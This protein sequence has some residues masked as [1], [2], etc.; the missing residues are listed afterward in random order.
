MDRKRFRRRP[1]MTLSLAVPGGSVVLPEDELEGIAADAELLRR[2]E[3]VSELAPPAPGLPSRRL[4]LLLL[5]A[6]V[7]AVVY[8][9]W[10]IVAGPIGTPVVFALLAAAEMFSIL[11]LLGFWWTVWHAD[12]R[13]PPTR[14][15]DLSVDALVTTCGEPVEVV[16]ATVRAVV[17]MRGPHRTILLDD[18]GRPEMRELAERAGAEY[19]ARGS[20][21]GAKAGNLNFGLAHATGD[22]VAAFDADHRPRPE[23]LER[24]LPYMADP[25][26]AWV[27]TP[28]YY[29]DSTHA[30]L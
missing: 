3:E 24:T 27:Q 23:F 2:I 7:A 4:K 6:P 20:R 29:A 10:W 8:A 12:R 28:Q 25:A 22:V 1:K 11:Q 19:L 26:M 15:P 13:P 18:A 21:R 5:V 16:E 9:T 30:D 14:M 17:A